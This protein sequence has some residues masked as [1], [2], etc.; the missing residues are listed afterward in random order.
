MK[1]LILLSLL[2]S[3]SVWADRVQLSC[4]F[5]ENNRTQNF[6]ITGNRDNSGNFELYGSHSNVSVSFSYSRQ[7]GRTMNVSVNG[8]T[9]TISLSGSGKMSYPM[10]GVGGVALNMLG[11]NSGERKIKVECDPRHMMLVPAPAPVVVAPTPLPEPVINAVSLIPL[12]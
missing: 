11:M 8:Q 1:H 5:K 10:G 6:N 2:A 9:N 4:S 12:T 7:S 3:S